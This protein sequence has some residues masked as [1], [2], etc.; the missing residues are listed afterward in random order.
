M[1][2]L[3]EGV[4]GRTPGV[5]ALLAKIDEGIRIERVEFAKLIEGSDV[6]LEEID[7]QTIGN[8][9]IPADEALHRGLI[10]EIL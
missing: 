1:P 3:Q 7:G 6:T 8:W 5:E 2:Q 4:A 9:Y 10:A